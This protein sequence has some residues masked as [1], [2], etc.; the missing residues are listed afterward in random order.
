MF[1]FCKEIHFGRFARRNIRFLRA[2]HVIHAG[3]ARGG[4]RY[5]MS[6]SRYGGIVWFVMGHFVGD[7]TLDFWVMYHDNGN[8]GY[9]RGGEVVFLS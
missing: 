7:I 5:L 4:T 1:L 8:W 6:E 3:Q 2:K 9:N